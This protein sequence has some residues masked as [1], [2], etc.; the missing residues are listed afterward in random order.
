LAENE[1]IVDTGSSVYVF[2][3]LSGE[4]KVT[5]K[6]KL[7]IRFFLYNETAP[8]FEYTF[9]VSRGFIYLGRKVRI[10]ERDLVWLLKRGI[11]KEG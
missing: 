7:K 11:L 8:L 6:R 5:N 2:R 4:F 10:H 1:L 3:P 9:S